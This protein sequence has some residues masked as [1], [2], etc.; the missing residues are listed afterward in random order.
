M[1]RRALAC[2]GC[3]L[4]ALAAPLARAGDFHAQGFI[5]ARVHF[6]DFDDRSWTD[7]GE[8]KARFGEQGKS[9]AL[10]GALSLSWQAS[11]S[12]LAVVDL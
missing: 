12:L 3:A 5:E 6:G 9:F 10:A 7:G 8:G 2:C 1:S 4:L 11:E